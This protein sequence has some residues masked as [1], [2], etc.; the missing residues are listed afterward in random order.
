VIDKWNVVVV[1]VVVDD[2]VVA[3]PGVDFISN[4]HF[5]ELRNLIRE[6]TVYNSAQ[7]TQ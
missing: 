7:L 1:V 3:A 4:Q 5:K 2:A 6:K